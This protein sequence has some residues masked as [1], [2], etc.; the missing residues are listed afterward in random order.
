MSLDETPIQSR[1]M[2]GVPEEMDDVVD[3]TAWDFPAGLMLQ[4]LE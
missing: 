1:L 2:K 4:K 3:V